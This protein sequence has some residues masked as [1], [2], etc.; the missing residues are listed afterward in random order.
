[1]AD[2][3]TPPA[4]P[5]PSDELQT[6]RESVEKLERKNRELL[7]EK[8]TI[9]TEAEE[10]REFRQQTEQQKLE[11]EG[12]YEAAKA[13]LQEQYD[14]DTKA[15]KDCIKELEDR[16][17]DLELIAP[18]TSVLATVMH[19][20]D[21][22]FVSGRL[23]PEQIEKG[24]DGPVVVNGL[25][26]IPLVDWAQANL[27][28]H[29]LKAPAPRGTG[30][31]ASRGSGAPALAGADPDL[32]FFTSDGFNLTEQSRIARTDPDRYAALRAAARSAAR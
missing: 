21:D 27:P 32:K 8:K 23:K 15:L 30:A 19:D 16:I 12:N 29:Y 26:R 28:R 7:E 13:R 5:K 31:P 4:A 10:L 24:P 20:P 2:E 17:R 22:V 14:R 18:A 6:L 11:S 1:M 9:K 25:E 3:L